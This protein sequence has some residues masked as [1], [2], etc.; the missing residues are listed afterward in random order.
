MPNGR[1]RFWL[2]VA[3]VATLTVTSATVL[4]ASAP[5][6]AATATFTPVA[7]T[8]VQSDT[9]SINY[10]TAKQIVVDKSP[11]RRSFLR[12]A[13][14]GLAGTVTG[15]KL[16]LRSIGGNEGSDSGGTWRRVSSTTWS[17]TGTTWN[18][19]PA[20]DGVAVG[21]LGVIGNDTWYELTVTAVVTGNGTYSFGASSASADGAYF[22]TRESGADAPQL[23]VSTDPPTPP[24]TP[25]PTTPSPTPSPSPT[26]PPPPSDPVFVGAGDIA[27][28]GAGDSA[29]A[30]LLDAIQGTV[31]TL[32]DNAYNS[33]TAAEYTSYYDPTWGRHKARTR[34]APGNHDYV[35]AGG[36]DYYAYFGAAAG[37]A[38]LGYYSFDLG[39]WHIVSLNSNINSAP[40]S[41]QVQWLRGDLAASTKP[42]TLAYWHHALFTSGAVDPPSPATRPL[43]QALYDFGAEVVLSGHNHQYERF[44]PMDPNGVLD[45]ARGLRSFVAGTGG[46]SHYAFGTIQPNSVARNSDTFGLL[47]LTLHAT[48]YDWQFVPE[49]G[50]TYADSGTG[51]CH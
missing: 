4:V 39:N 24:P 42:C 11:L 20:L 44:A 17:E 22:D 49:A 31:Y 3:T 50:R 36:S 23:V 38:G 7:D 34:P 37:P 12:F 45:E 8:Y 26:L 21:T 51:T 19:Q 18:N 27:T 32:G 13:V 48:S 46:A 14:S 15:A 35:T 43:Y 47:K 5:A 28:N 10:G 33:G 16:R 29:T 1:G 41:P 2:S 40:T 25:P 6:A 9:A 30:A